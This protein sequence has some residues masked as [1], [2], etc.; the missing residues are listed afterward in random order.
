MTSQQLISRLRSNQLT[1][2]VKASLS[3][4]ILSSMTSVAI[5]QQCI[6]INF[7][8]PAN[9]NSSTLP[10]VICAT[11]SADADDNDVTL[12]VSDL[13]PTTFG[14]FLN[15]QTAGPPVMPPGSAGNLCLSGAIG[16]YS[17]SI[18]MTTSNGDAALVLDL[19]TTPTPNNFVP[20]VNGSNWC[21]QAWFRDTIPPTGGATSN[22]T[23]AVEIPFRAAGTVG[24]V[25]G[26]TPIVGAGGD[27]VTFTING[28]PPGTTKADICEAG[29]V[30]ESLQGNQWVARVMTVPPGFGG[31]QFVEGAVG[32]GIN[33]PNPTPVPGFAFP[34]EV[35]VIEVPPNGQA[36]AGGVMFDFQESATATASGWTLLGGDLKT[37]L[38]GDWQAGDIVEIELHFDTDS[39]G[40]HCDFFSTEIEIVSANPTTQLCALSVATHLQFELSQ[41]PACSSVQVTAPGG[42][43]VCVTFPGNDIIRSHPRNKVVVR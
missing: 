16:R 29:F 27:L 42:G 23:D 28:L 1:G 32:M 39:P 18:F 31:V 37:F 33:I 4:A 43:L 21:F 40:F 13:P 41:L 15:S 35:T 20:V 38:G 9:P 26:V 8:G 11:G 12:N 2:L 5:A 36:L 24:T 17:S 7:C 3:L 19:P 30:G 25:V 22:F 14:L 6:G 34:G 10:G